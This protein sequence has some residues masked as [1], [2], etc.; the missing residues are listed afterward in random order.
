M[1]EGSHVEENG[2]KVL[3]GKERLAARVESG[4]ENFR[5]KVEDKGK[6]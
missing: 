1:A 3:L 2:D 6:G 4:V 5:E